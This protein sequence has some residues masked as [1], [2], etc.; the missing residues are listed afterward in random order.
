[1]P[2]FALAYSAEDQPVAQQIASSLHG[3]AVP[4]HVAIGRDNEGALLTDQVGIIGGPAVFLISP[5][6]LTNPNCLLHLENLLIGHRSCYAVQRGVNLADRADRMRFVSHWQDRYIDLRRGLETYGEDE[7]AAFD[8]Y[9][10]KIRETS[11]GVPSLLDRLG[12][13]Q[14]I[15]WDEANPAQLLVPSESPAPEFGKEELIAQAWEDYDRGQQNTAL[16]ALQRA[17]KQQP[18]EV[19]LRYHYALMLALREGG[20][21][22]AA[23]EVLDDLLDD[24][25]Y[26]PG[27]LLLSAEL[28]R[29]DGVHDRARNDYERIYEFAPDS[30]GLRE[31]LG[32]LIAEHFSAEGITAKQYL[33]EAEDRGE[34]TAAGLYTYAQL[35]NRPEDRVRAEELLLRCVARDPDFAPAYYQLAVLAYQADHRNAASGYFKQATQLEPAFATTANLAVFGAEATTVDLEPD[36]RELEVPRTDRSSSPRQEEIVLISGAT[37]GIGR[38]TAQRLAADG[39]RLILLGRRAELLDALADELKRTHG[40]LSQLV[41][42]DVRD[43]DGVGKLLDQLPEEWKQVGVLINN[44]G[45]AKGFDPIQEGRLEHWDEMI[46]VNLRGLLYLTRAVTPGMVERGRG[47]VLNV[48]STAG[49]EVYPNGNVYCATKHAVD[50]LTY[51]MRLDL[52]KHG[53]RVGQICPAHVEETEFAVVRFDGD[54]ERAKIYDDFQPLRASDVAE[55]IAFMINQPPHVNILD[56]VL[57]GTQQASSTVVDRS[58]RERF[59]AND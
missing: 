10:Q 12:Q 9:L 28:Y 59:A 15:R 42:L 16:E 29:A 36:T 52:V 31:A 19:E 33:Q 30:P 3:G 58:G 50:A 53:I 8:R 26:H 17:V 1:M 57:Q 14:R 22:Q 32:V 49:K 24:D 44:A 11:I 7:Q 39:Y 37:S 48:A 25:P 43:R 46:D 23:R 6:F 13:L 41:H 35:L 51:A 34:L 56:M 47:M 18:E 54:R 4:V 21:P 2:A 40:T 45:K 5:A 20:G 27:A 38:A 55:A